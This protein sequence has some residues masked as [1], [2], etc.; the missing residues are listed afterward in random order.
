M[1]RKAQPLS[2]EF[3]LL[4][5]IRQTPIHTYDLAKKL[6]SDDELSILWRFNQSQLYAILDKL[7][8]STLIES[9]IAAGAAFP[10]RK[11]YSLTEKGEKLFQEW[12]LSP[13]EQPHMMRSAFLPK[14]YFLKNEPY[15]QF[16]TIIRE[17]KKV[18]ELSLEKFTERIKALPP[19]AVYQQMVFDFRIKNIE[20]IIQWL[21]ACLET[22]RKNDQ[23]D[24]GI[25]RGD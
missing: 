20:G 21:S 4:G 14:L 13:V 3:I 24:S 6:E 22:H 11:V 12:K 2:V 18:C 23:A 15:E 19:E 17:Q 7:E 25:Q 16:E 10:F 5:L 8:K 9:R 1:A